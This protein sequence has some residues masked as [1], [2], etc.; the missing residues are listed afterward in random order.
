MPTGLSFIFPFIV[1]RFGILI[2]FSSVFVQE[3]PLTI[4]QYLWDS[5]ISIG[6]CVTPVSGNKKTCQTKTLSPP[7]TLKYNVYIYN[8]M[9]FF[10]LVVHASLKYAKL[11]TLL[12]SIKSNFVPILFLKEL[13][14]NCLANNLDRGNKYE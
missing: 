9:F 12:S 4:F 3:N 8:I 10:P 5:E 13:F 11:K 14:R 7:H 1:P 2:S 6:Y